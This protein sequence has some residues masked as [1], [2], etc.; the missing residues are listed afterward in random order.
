M[1]FNSCEFLIFFPIAALRYYLVPFLQRN[2]D[3]KKVP[4]VTD[5]RNLFVVRLTGFEPATPSVGG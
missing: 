1:I 2:G 3:Y 4:F 5:K